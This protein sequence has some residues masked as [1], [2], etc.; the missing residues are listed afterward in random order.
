MVE[1]KVKPKVGDVFQIPVSAEV[2]GFG[3]ILAQYEREMLLMVIFAY[4]TKNSENPPL[5]QIVASPPLLIGNS[6]DAKIWHGHWPVI[7]N[8]PPDLSRFPLPHYKVQIGQDMCVENYNSDRARPAT[9]S[10]LARLA[11]RKC[12]APIRLEKAL[13]AHYGFGV[14]EESFDSLRAEV[15]MQ[16]VSI[17]V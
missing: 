1:T 7:G 6:L 17:E 10:E 2:S 14:W 13:K 16:S 9:E 4:Q 3:Q 5:E 12:V 15:A 11:F 8:V